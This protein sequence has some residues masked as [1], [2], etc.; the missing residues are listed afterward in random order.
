VLGCVPRR[1]R[2]RH[3]TGPQCLPGRRRAVAGPERAR[4]RPAPVPAAQRLALVRAPL[5]FRLFLPPPPAPRPPHAVAR[6]TVGLVRRPS[7][8]AGQHAA[9]AQRR[10]RRHLTAPPAVGTLP[11]TKTAALRRRY[12][13]LHYPQERTRARGLRRLRWR[14]GR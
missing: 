5:P 14:A 2:T 8:R 12:G 11:G 7:H 3:R 6:E 10:S 9:A 1:G 4:D 13:L